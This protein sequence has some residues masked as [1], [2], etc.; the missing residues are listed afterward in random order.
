MK[1]ISL[2]LMTWLALPWTAL[3]QEYP[4]RPIRM[5]VPFLAGGPT[6]YTSR[7]VAGGLEK[8]LGQPVLVDNKPGG[9]TLIGIEI[10]AHAPADGYTLAYVSPSFSTGP[11]LYKTN[12]DPLKDFQPITQ[13]S[14]TT[15]VLLVNNDVPAKSVAELIQWLKVNGARANYASVG[16][17]STTHMEA[18]AFKQMAGVE[19]SHIPYK[20]SAQAIVDL[21]A[22]RVQVSFDS[23]GS[24]LPFIKDSRVRALAVAGPTRNH[25]LPALP[26]VAEAGLPGYEFQVW[27]GMFAPAGTPAPIVE[28]LSR[29]IRATLREAVIRQKLIDAN[30]DPVGS[31]VAEFTAFIRKDVEQAA[32]LLKK[33]NI[34][35][36]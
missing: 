26:T 9:N 29:D 20:G 22:G 7:T 25:L 3:A 12:Y 21:I 24:A 35:G 16:T 11:A 13:I 19:M 18:E 27:I 17:G 6:D 33:A 32:A 23:T 10:V 1:R 28:R 2:W 5:V 30:S 15:H 34:K 4:T 31:S 36:E 8:R 14:T